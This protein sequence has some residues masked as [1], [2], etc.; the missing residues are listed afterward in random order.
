MRIPIF[1]FKNEAI[2]MMVLS[3]G[4]AVIALAALFVLWLV[5][6]R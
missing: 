3:L 4:P 2:W 1:T 6:P 5:R